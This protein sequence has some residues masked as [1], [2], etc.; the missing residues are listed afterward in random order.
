[1]I[2][3][4]GGGMPKVFEIMARD[5]ILSKGILRH[6]AAIEEQLE[7]AE[8]VTEVISPPIP[9][10]ETMANCVTSSARNFIHACELFCFIC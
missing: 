9:A 2:D 6:A 1:M 3:S 8:E 4:A 7:E 5:D 10:V